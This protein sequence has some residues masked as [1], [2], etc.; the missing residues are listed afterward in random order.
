MD[1]SFKKRDRSR[2]SSKASTQT[3]RSSTLS[4]ENSEIISP[5]YDPENDYV[6]T[7]VHDPLRKVDLSID[8]AVTQRLMDLKN[9]IYIHPITSW[10]LTINDAV[11]QGLVKATKDMHTSYK[12]EK[13]EEIKNKTNKN[14][15]SYSIRYV[16]D[17]QLGCIRSINEAVNLGLVDLE[18]STLI[19]F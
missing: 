6:I 11:E 15:K 3:R 17:T 4:D 7:S 18:K 5:K 10:K 9:K 2:R 19:D 1:A 13:P 16:V 8:D 12:I 14:V